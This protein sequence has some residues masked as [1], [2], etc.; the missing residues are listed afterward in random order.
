MAKTTATA[1]GGDSIH[2]RSTSDAT[3]SGVAVIGEDGTDNVV[4]PHPSFGANGRALP[5]AGV[6]YPT[7]S[8]TITTST[9]TV[10]ISNIGAAGNVTAYIYGT[11]AGV[12]VVFEI[13]PDNT[14]WFPVSATREDT[15][16][17]E[18]ASGA[19]PA[20][21]VRA[22]TTGAPGFSYFRVR[23]TAWTSGTANV[24]LVAGSYP[25]E[26]LVAVGAQRK[27]PSY[28]AVFRTATR[29]Y[30]TLFT[31][32]AN[33]RKQFAT[34]HHA[35]TA[36]KTVKLR[37]VQVMVYSATTAAPE[38]NVDLVRITS[39]PATGNPAITPAL[40]DNA[41]AAAEVTCLALPT[42]A[43]TEGALYSSHYVSLGLTTTPPTTN[44][45]PVPGIYELVGP[46]VGD[47]EPKFP[48][49][50]AGVLE[51]WAVTIDSTTA[52]VVAARVIVD[53]TEE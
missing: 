49:I 23:A 19:L 30:N 47:N 50:R 32:T 41:D 29:P 45:P 40:A 18:A 24:A 20:N 38:L 48:I 28:R 44:P 6:S 3:E 53:F 12:S 5:V 43:A 13:S 33:T 39:A 8:G 35:A 2:T 51:G 37:R 34:I 46:G 16:G 11:Y 36:V 4:G 42:T 10:T 26:P 22:W 27:V 17:S 1:V 21:T 52:A 25:F 9:S 14:N 31:F 15:G 7:Q